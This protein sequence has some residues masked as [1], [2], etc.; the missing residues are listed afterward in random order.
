V[1]TA[2]C[3]CYASSMGIHLHAPPLRC[4]GGR[5]SGASGAAQGCP[6]RRGAPVVPPTGCASSLAFLV[7]SRR[8]VHRNVRRMA[9]AYPLAAC[10]GTSLAAGRLSWPTAAGSPRT[11]AAVSGAL[12][13]GGIVAAAARSPMCSA[14]G[15]I[16][17][18]SAKCASG[19]LLGGAF[20]TSPAEAPAAVLWRSLSS[21]SLAVSAAWLRW[22]RSSA[23][24]AVVGRTLSAAAGHLVPTPAAGRRTVVEQMAAAAIDD[25]GT[26]AVARGG[27]SGAD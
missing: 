6:P 13:F 27:G 22:S 3:P 2:K 7:P 16:I 26:S 1:A 21:S 9:A 24:A 17:G 11:P 12:T 4:C 14:P 10:S 25:V 15:L 8:R 5:E 18:G 23:A 19:T 20:W